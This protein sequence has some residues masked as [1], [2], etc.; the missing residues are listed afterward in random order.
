MLLVFFIGAVTFAVILIYIGPR[1]SKNR[2][3]S[4]S[5]IDR[6]VDS[7]D[8]S[9]IRPKDDRGTKDGRYESQVRRMSRLSR[10]NDNELAP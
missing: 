6:E 8:Y 3:Y 9:S 1:L 10:E 4:P 5:G 7:I 2:G